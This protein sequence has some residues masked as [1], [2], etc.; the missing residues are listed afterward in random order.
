MTSGLGDQVINTTCV[1]GRVRDSREEPNKTWRVF[2]AI[3]LP[4]NIRTRIAEHIERLRSTTPGVRVSWSREDNLHLTLKFLEDI[5]V[6]NVE[7][8]SAAAAIAASKVE[9]FEIVIEGCGAFPL[10]GQPRVLWIGI[11]DPSGKLS[12]LNRTL[13]DECAHAG[14]AREPR[15]FHPHLTIARIRQPRGAR[16]LAARHREIGFNRE[17]VGVSETSVIRSELRS[18]GSKHT[19]VSRHTFSPSTQ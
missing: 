15:A 5:P 18:E 6:A 19:T 14:F 16:Q 12:E 17:I 9:P 8:L 3:E 1:S 13:E 4:L 10:R 2:I 11:D 7:K